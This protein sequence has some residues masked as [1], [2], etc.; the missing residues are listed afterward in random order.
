MNEAHN[1]ALKI[2]RLQNRAPPFRCSTPIENSASG[3]EVQLS[4]TTVDRLLARE[5]TNSP[6]SAPTTI[7]IAVVKSKENPY[8]K[9]EVGKCYRCGS[10][11]TSP[12]NA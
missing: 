4:F 12:M 3:V 9:P 6:A 7:T 8:T 1:K 5:S 10:Q 11:D 2:E